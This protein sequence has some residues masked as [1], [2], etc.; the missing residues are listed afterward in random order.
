V[1]FDE[2]RFTSLAVVPSQ[3]FTFGGIRS[4]LEKFCKLNKNPK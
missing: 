2:H 4:I 3:D 1:Y